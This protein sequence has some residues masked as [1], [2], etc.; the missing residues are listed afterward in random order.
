METKFKSALRPLALA[1]V[2]LMISVQFAFGQP[3]KLYGPQ[4]PPPLGVTTT[5][6]PASTA[7]IGLPGGITYTYQ[8]FP[9]AGTTT[10]YWSILNG[11]VRASMQSCSNMTTLSYAGASL[12]TGYA[13]W[14]GPNLGVYDDQYNVWRYYS[15]K[16]EIRVTDGNGTPIPL[17]LA[18]SIGLPSNCG[19]VVPIT[20][21]GMVVRVNMLITVSGIPI[22]TRFNS[23]ETLIS[24]NVCTSVDWGYYWVNDPPVLTVKQPLNLDEGASA[25]ITNAHLM[26]TDLES[27]PTQ[28]Y[29]VHDPGD[30]TPMPEHGVLKRGGIEVSHGEQFSVTEIIANASVSLQY[31]H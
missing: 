7:A 16:C 25:T 22:N 10:L 29:F 8:N 5:H 12:N 21:P 17:I 15:P 9:L 14:T 2:C 6:T 20:D 19:A 3:D 11:Q 27:P 31:H 28:V 26:A 1:I 18:T 23:I 30:Q 13:F 4:D 24:H